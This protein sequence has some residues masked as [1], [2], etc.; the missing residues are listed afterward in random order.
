MAILLKTDG[1]KQEVFPANKK[2]FTLKELQDY[3]GGYIERVRPLIPSENG[4]YIIANEEGLLLGMKFNS[5]ASAK[6]GI[7]LVGDVL[8]CSREEF[9]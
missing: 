8:V 5:Q 3:V 2:D 7:P 1:T 6:T 4:E 9:F